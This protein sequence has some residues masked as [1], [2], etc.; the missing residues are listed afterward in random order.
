MLFREG[1]GLN[2]KTKPISGVWMN[3]IAEGKEDFVQKQTPISGVWT[4]VGAEGYVRITKKDL[5][6]KEVKVGYFGY[7]I[8][9][10]IGFVLRFI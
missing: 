6:W 5:F 9:I 8:V 2:P 1:N 3:V 10:M 4:N 7:V